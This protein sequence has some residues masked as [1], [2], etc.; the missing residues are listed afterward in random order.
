MGVNFCKDCGTKISDAV[1][2]CPGCG[3][4]IHAGN[5][6]ADAKVAVMESGQKGSVKDL[7][8]NSGPLQKLLAVIWLSVV[9]DAIF[10]VA[11]CC[12]VKEYYSLG[13]IGTILF[14]VVA[15]GWQ[16]WLAVA[17]GKL[18]SWARKSFIVLA[19]LQVLAVFWIGN[20][21]MSIVDLV[22]AL[23]C[24]YLFFGDE[25]VRAFKVDAQSKGRRAV[26]N[27]HHCIAYWSAG[28]MW[29]VVMVAAAEMHNGTEAWDNDCTEAI[30]AGSESAR[31]DMI[32]Y[33]AEVFAAK[34]FESPVEQA[35]EYVDDYIKANKNQ[36]GG[37]RRNGNSASEGDV[38]SG[39]AKHPSRVVLGYKMIIAIIAGIGSL[40]AGAYSWFGRFIAK[41]KQS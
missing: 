36:S 13:R 34:G 4:R 26:I 21:F 10:T 8:A 33:V 31:T 12:N 1:E 23:Y 14:G 5:G 15:L 16:I 29:I 24:T 19:A 2:F 41:N 25:V 27:R 22:L 3:R 7:W 39:I 9:V 18:K 11:D 37:N 20:T 30:L 17:V 32:D 28:V 6:F 35:T 40:L 38:L